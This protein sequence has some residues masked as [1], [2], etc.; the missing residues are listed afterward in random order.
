MVKRH[1]FVECDVT[2]MGFEVWHRTEHH[3]RG[4]VS[5]SRGPSWTRIST[6]TGACQYGTREMS[7]M[8]SVMAIS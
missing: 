8:T 7:V 1:T 4:A 6:D 3:L 5:T 2:P